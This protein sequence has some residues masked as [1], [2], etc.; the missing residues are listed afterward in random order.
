MKN[1]KRTHSKPGKGG[2]KYKSV[3]QGNNP[4]IKTGQ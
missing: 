1:S 3:Y 2:R 4:Q